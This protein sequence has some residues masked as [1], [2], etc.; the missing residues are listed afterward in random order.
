M[1]GY[2]GKKPVTLGGASALFSWAEMEWQGL[3]FTVHWPLKITRL[4]E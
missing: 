1:A 4:G 3:T 2:V